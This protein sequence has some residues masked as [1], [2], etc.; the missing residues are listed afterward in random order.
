M[1]FVARDNVPLNR[2]VF[3]TQAQEVTNVILA[4]LNEYI[5]KRDRVPN[6]AIMMGL[7][8]AISTHLSG[9]PKEHRDLEIQLMKK[10]FAASMETLEAFEG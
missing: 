6:G 4:A 7:C 3:E 1:K 2:D 8:V 5:E 10:L 9:I